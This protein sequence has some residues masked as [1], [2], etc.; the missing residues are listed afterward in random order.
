A[1]I[2]SREPARATPIHIAPGLSA[3]VDARLFKIVLGNLLGNAWKFTAKHAGA[4]IWF[5]GDHGTFW[6]R[7]AGAGFDM[8]YAK[9]LF[10][11]FQRLHAAESYEGTGVGLA[12]VHRIITHHGGRIWVEAE[13][14]RGATFFFTLGDRPA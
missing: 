1:E 3:R 12:T 2:R 4:E 10:R 14:D 6:I 8:A 11:P 9:K 13:I 7:D 5:G